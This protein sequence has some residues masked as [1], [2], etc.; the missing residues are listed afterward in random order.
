M[1]DRIAPMAA[2]PAVLQRQIGRESTMF[3]TDTAALRGSMTADNLTDM[4]DT[5]SAG[6]LLSAL[7][8]DLRGAVMGAGRMAGNALTGRNTATRSEIARML[9]S[10]DV[11]AALAPALRAQMKAG[12]Q[13]RV[14]EALLRSL[15][16]PTQ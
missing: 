3:G 6:P 4:A 16:R 1:M 2:D 11:D 15:A 7:A 5:A 8:G 14:V 13:N 10:R 12:G 9:L